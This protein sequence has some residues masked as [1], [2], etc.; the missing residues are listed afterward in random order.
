MTSNS[1]LPH[2]LPVGS[3]KSNLSPSESKLAQMIAETR[4][5]PLDFVKK[6]FHWGEGDLTKYEAPDEWQTEFLLEIENRLKNNGEG[7]ALKFATSS[8]HGVGKTAVVSWLILWFISTR[9]NSAIVVTANTQTQLSTKTWRELNRWLGRMLHRHW[10]QWQATRLFHVLKPETWY[11]AA[12]PWSENNPEAFAGTHETAGVLILFDE[13]SAIVDIIWEN[14]EGA[15]T[16][17]GAI[18]CA[19]GNPTRNDGYFYRCFHDLKHRWQTYKVDSRK[20]MVANKAQLQQWVDDYGEDSDFVRVRVRGE[21]P[22]ISINQFISSAIIQESMGIPP[23][24]SSY[25][26]RPVIGVDVARFGEDRSV[27]AVRRGKTV[28]ENIQTFLGIDTMELAGFVVARYR[29]EGSNGIVC[30][31]GVGVGAGVVDRLRQYG[32]PVIDVQSG[33]KSSDPRTYYNKRCEL[34]GK[35]KDWLSAGGILPKN[36]DL[37]RELSIIEYQINNKL[38]IQLA[39]KEDIRRKNDGKSTDLADPI[40]FTFAV[41]SLFSFTQN[42]K[43]KRV[44]NTNFY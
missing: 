29:D 4:D 5:S 31:D 10:F 3:L 38:Q 16:T 19:F 36:K 22:R 41:D 35:L 43:A 17:H 12:I 37:A 32:I 28:D 14:I 23:D 11:A 33:A 39:S 24:R 9:P 18:W 21:F 34:Y 1:L 30:V 40:A 20:A 25:H 8:G 2:L 26:D 44:I 27:I 15:L 42:A 13:A 7:A 6:F